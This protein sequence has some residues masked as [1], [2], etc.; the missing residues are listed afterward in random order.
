MEPTGPGGE[1]DVIYLQDILDAWLGADTARVILPITD[2]YV[3]HHGALGSFATAYLPEGCDVAGLTERL[4]ALEGMELV[5]GN[6]EGCERFELPEDRMGDLILVSGKHKVLGTSADRHDLSALEEP[7][8]S[9][10]GISEQR[11]PLLLNRPTPD[12]E[13]ER[14]LRNFDAFDLALNYAR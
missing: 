13:P 3:V 12:L 4:N 5:L 9:H 10:G 11:V 6:S 7:L 2:P 14:P 1:P 8:R